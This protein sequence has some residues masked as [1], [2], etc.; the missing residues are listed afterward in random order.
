M[1]NFE[2]NMGGVLDEKL[3]QVGVNLVYDSNSD[4]VGV[5]LSGIDETLC[6]EA[7]FELV[8][9]YFKV[10]DFI[11]RGAN[12]DKIFDDYQAREIEGLIRAVMDTINLWKSRVKQN[13]KNVEDVCVVISGEIV[14]WVKK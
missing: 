8:S 5:G 9:K 2:K 1:K 6:K 12:N 7:V 11:R 4:F 10:M 3:R 14:K 13:T